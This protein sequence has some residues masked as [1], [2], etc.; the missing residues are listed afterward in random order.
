MKPYSSRPP[1]APPTT[2]PT[3]IEDLSSPPPA[4][5]SIIGRTSSSARP[6]SDVKATPASAPPAAAG[7]S[8]RIPTNNRTASGL[9]PLVDENDLSHD[10]DEAQ[11]AEP[12]DE[13]PVAMDLSESDAPLHKKL[14]IEPSSDPFIQAGYHPPAA[15]A[16]LPPSLSPTAPSAAAKRR[17]AERAQPILSESTMARF[18]VHAHSQR[19]SLPPRKWTSPHA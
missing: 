19:F 1:E 4:A 3:A 18:P 14:K 10:L 2:Q 13:G 11:A 7:T 6:A 12:D 15:S 8:L 16:S 17:H 5:S 9:T